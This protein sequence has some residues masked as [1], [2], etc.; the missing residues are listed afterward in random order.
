MAFTCDMLS[1]AKEFWA[2]EFNHLWQ[3]SWLYSYGGTKETAALRGLMI[4]HPLEH[5]ERETWM[6]ALVHVDS[7]A[8]AAAHVIASTYPS[9]SILLAACID[10]CR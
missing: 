9:L 7:V 6:H 2:L 5:K 4:Q 8:P 10:P 3:E 1:L